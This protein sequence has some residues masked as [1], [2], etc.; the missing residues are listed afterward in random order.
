[1]S[2]KRRSVSFLMA[3][4]IRSAPSLAQISN[5]AGYEHLRFKIA[6]S[7]ISDTSTAVDDGIKRE[8]PRA[9][10]AE[11]RRSSIYRTVHEEP[12]NLYEM[13]ESDIAHFASWE[14]L[15]AD[16][17]I[18]GFIRDHAAQGNPRIFGCYVFDTKK[19]EDVFHQGYI[20]EGDNWRQLP[21]RCL[22][23]FEYANK[24]Y[25]LDILK[26]AREETDRMRPAR[27]NAQAQPPLVRKAQP[28]T[29]GTTAANIVKPG[30]SKEIAAAQF[31]TIPLPTPARPVY[32][33]SAATEGKER[34]TISF[35]RP[36]NSRN[37]YNYDGIKLI[38]WKS[39]AGK[40]FHFTWCQDGSPSQIETFAS[41]AEIGQMQAA[42]ANSGA[43]RDTDGNAF[44]WP[45]FAVGKKYQIEYW[46]WP[47]LQQNWFERPGYA[48]TSVASAG[49]G[50]GPSYAAILSVHGSAYANSFNGQTTTK[51]GEVAYPSPFGGIAYFERR[52]LSDLSCRKLAAE[53]F[54]CSYKIAKTF[55]GDNDSIF[56]KLTAAFIPNQ[57]PT[58]FTYTYVRKGG[59][60]SSPE[61]ATEVRVEAEAARK[62]QSERASQGSTSA[63]CTVYGGVTANWEGG[64]GM[65]SG[66]SWDPSIRTPC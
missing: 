16:F 56:G 36:C 46:S 35:R 38:A 13:G 4:W 31:A 59:S 5:P 60:W 2:V 34:R 61:L 39:P 19:R 42:M 29:T 49:I 52:Q 8:I 25:L 50:G 47:Q 37:D 21:G 63:P 62:R 66:M 15:D 40:Y 43:L 64:N 33:A 17:L 57:P 48:D 65:I 23:E 14:E 9:M 27:A 1:M 54:R 11:I 28:P 58:P 24:A 44:T 55:E 51:P 32:T 53:T 7:T 12:L 45:A 41:E 26:V 18:A 20:I 6:V 22:A 30:P 10:I 3:I